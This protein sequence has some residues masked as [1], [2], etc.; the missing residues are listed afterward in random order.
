MTMMAVSFLH[1]FMRVTPGACNENR[2]LM[3][4]REVECRREVRRHFGVISGAF[5]AHFGRVVCARGYS[6]GFV[7]RFLVYVI[8]FLDLQHLFDDPELQA[9]GEGVEQQ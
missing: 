6:C 1:T 5:L 3:A 7:S 8:R 4:T 2:Y 9:L